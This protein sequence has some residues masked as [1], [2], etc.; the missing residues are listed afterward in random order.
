MLSGPPPNMNP[1]TPISSAASAR[2]ATVAMARKNFTTPEAASGSLAYSHALLFQRLLQFAGLKHFADDIATADK[3]TLH[4]KLRDR[5]PVGIG[6][7]AIPDFVGFK[8][9]DAFVSH[10]EMV[11]DLHDLA[12]KAAHRK[13]RRAFHEQHDVVCLHFIVDELLDSHGI[14]SC[15]A[16]RPRDVDICTKK[17]TANPRAPTGFTR[18][19]GQKMCPRPRKCRPGSAR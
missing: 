15:W 6:L 9:V 16:R 13:L 10:P 14:S 4:V 19:S 2:S 5:R 12:G 3:F 18:F 7:D 1:E 17:V 11:E 8:N